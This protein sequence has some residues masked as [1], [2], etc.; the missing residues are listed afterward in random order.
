MCCSRLAFYKWLPHQGFLKKYILFAENNKI[1]NFWNTDP[2]YFHFCKWL[3]SLFIKWFTFS[4]CLC[5]IVFL[6]VFLPFLLI[7]LLNSLL[8]L[9]IDLLKV[10][11][12]YENHHIHKE[13]SVS[14][15]ATIQWCS[16][17][18]TS[19]SGGCWIC[20][21]QNVL[22]VLRFVQCCTRYLKM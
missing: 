11:H 17:C 22:S 15:L 16:E 4:C 2:H 19:Q 18:S 21:W 1:V 20:L 6:Y 14:G 8:S 10:W 5:I 13:Q 3:L 12:S 9:S 7:D